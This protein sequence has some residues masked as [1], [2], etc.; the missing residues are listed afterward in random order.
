MA[1]QAISST[2]FNCEWKYDVFLNFRGKDTRNGFTGHLYFALC[3]NGI[4]TFMDDEELRKGD[5]ITP[6]LFKAIEQ[7]RMAIVIF[8]ND[9]ASSTFCLN[10]LVTILQFIKGNSRL[11]LPIFY[12]V[13]PLHV[14]HQEGKYREALAMHERKLKDNVDK[15]QRWKA[16]L[17]E[18]ANIS[19]FHLSVG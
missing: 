4:R 15:L 16:A 13:E 9:Y 19:S 11:V 5:E 1:V 6:A 10:E 17:H 2:S 18:A 14:R 7:S 12:D 3:E 8:S